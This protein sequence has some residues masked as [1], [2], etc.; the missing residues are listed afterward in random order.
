MVVFN[1]ILSN[2]VEDKID[3]KVYSSIGQVVYQKNTTAK[4]TKIVRLE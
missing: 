2:F 1:V 4:R 3:V